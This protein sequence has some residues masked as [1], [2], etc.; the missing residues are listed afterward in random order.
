MSETTY[1]PNELTRK[2]RCLT[3]G[4]REDSQKE[5]ASFSH[6]LRV[7]QNCCQ[8]V[9]LCRGL[10]GNG[11][12]HHSQLQCPYKP[13][14]LTQEETLVAVASRINRLKLIICWLNSA[15]ANVCWSQRKRKSHTFYLLQDGLWQS[16]SQH[17]LRTPKYCSAMPSLNDHFWMFT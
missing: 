12:I 13:S 8:T 11:V 4:G 7:S 17:N 10:R 5:A 1:F 6:I 2:Q 3:L 14:H 15:G 16:H 9:T